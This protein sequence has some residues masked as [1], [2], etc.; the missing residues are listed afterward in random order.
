MPRPM[1]NP[2]RREEQTSSLLSMSIAK[3]EEQLSEKEQ[4]MADKILRKKRSKRYMEMLH[5]LDVGGHTQNQSTIDEMMQEIRLEF[6]EMDINGILLGYVSIC[7]LSEPYEVHTLD[8]IQGIVQHYKCG[9][10]LPD[11]M[12]KARGIAMSGSY[13]FIEVYSSCCRAVSADGSVAVIPM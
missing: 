13:E 7:Y 8:M 4:M 2:E 3:T 9:E 11:G 1:L 5:K 6:P 10:A 12:E